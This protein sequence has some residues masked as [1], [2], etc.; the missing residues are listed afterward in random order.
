[1]TYNYNQYNQYGQR[2]Q[3]QAQQTQQGY[4]S[5]GRWYPAQ[6]QRVPTV[7]RNSDLGTPSSGR[8]TV[9]SPDTGFRWGMVYQRLPNGLYH[10]VSESG[11][12]GGRP[13]PFAHGTVMTELELYKKLVE[14][15]A[16][17]L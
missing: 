13:N 6:A 17:R 4:W 12:G 3:P 5:G 7:R 16:I 8:Y 2:I 9:T 1:V 14:S 15:G 10:V 11:A